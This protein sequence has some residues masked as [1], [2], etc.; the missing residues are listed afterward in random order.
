MTDFGFS[1]VAELLDAAIPNY[2]ASHA[3]PDGDVEDGSRPLA[4]SKMRFGQRGELAV[5]LHGNRQFEFRLES[6][7]DANFVP[8]CLVETT[9]RFAG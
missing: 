3:R 8:A 6:F 4:R 1:E 2:P 7:R 9:V 5:V